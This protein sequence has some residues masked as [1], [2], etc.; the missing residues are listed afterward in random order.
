MGVCSK[1]NMDENCGG[2][3]QA[4]ACSPMSM[5]ASNSL[6]S[7]VH[8]VA[9][10]ASIHGIHHLRSNGAHRSTVEFKVPTA[11][12]HTASRDTFSGATPPSASSVPMGPIRTGTGETSRASATSARIRATLQRRVST[13]RFQVR[14][15]VL[16]GG[17]MSYGAS[18][19]DLFRRA[20]GYVQK[21]QA[22]PRGRA[23]A[24][25]STAA[26]PPTRSLRRR[27][28]RCRNQAPRRR[29]ARFGRRINYTPKI[30]A[31]T[32]RNGIATRERSRFVLDSVR[33][34]HIQR[35]R[36]VCTRNSDQR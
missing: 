36:H 4:T 28:G 33:D 15:N 11:S 19:P 1:G 6:D 22:D 31:A 3:T 5:V 7:G 32:P 2:C 8:D 34:R 27:L 26:T 9:L 29:C 20:A 24:I 17:L 35:R 12:V 10:V 14:E 13:T 16:A 25:T 21:I 23:T 18:L 30:L